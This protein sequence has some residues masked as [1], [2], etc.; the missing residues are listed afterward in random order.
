MLD[1]PCFVLFGYC[2]AGQIRGCAISPDGLLIA[3]GSEDC[4]VKVV[5]AATGAVIHTLHNDLYVR[6]TNGHPWL[7]LMFLTQ[8]Y[9]IAWHSDGNYRFVVSGADGKLTEFICS[10]GRWSHR[11]VYVHRTYVRLRYEN[12]KV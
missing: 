1:R 6:S 12:L 7:M 10:N 4:T 8:A 2:C 11:T 5:D 9:G 3:I